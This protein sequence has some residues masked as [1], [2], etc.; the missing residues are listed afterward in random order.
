[1]T[2]YD[3]I[4]H[5]EAIELL[6]MY[7]TTK[8]KNSVHDDPNPYLIAYYLYINRGEVDV[9]AHLEDRVSH[10]PVE[11]GELLVYDQE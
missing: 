6:K 10:M 3:R 4:K 1:M 11:E 8:D 2:M 7:N 9:L 5:K